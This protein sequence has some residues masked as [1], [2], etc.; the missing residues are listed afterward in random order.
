MIDKI[1]D[2]L[3]NG[4]L[5]TEEK[6]QGIG[7]LVQYTLDNYT[8]DQNKIYTETYDASLDRREVR[9][10]SLVELDEK[11][12]KEA[13]G[14]DLVLDLMLLANF[15]KSSWGAKD[16]CVSCQPGYILFKVEY[17]D[18]EYKKIIDVEE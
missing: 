1:F 14:N 3:C 15:A 17:D 5:T 16:T 4:D 10:M 6:I 18:N 13:F 9:Q 11:V 12:D 7:T 8:D 2:A